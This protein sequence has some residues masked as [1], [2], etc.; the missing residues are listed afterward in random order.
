MA[1]SHVFDGNVAPENCVGRRK[2]G[3]TEDIELLKEVVANDAHVCRRG[4]VTENFE[5]AA[6]AL[7][8]SNALPWIT[9]GKHCN[10]RYK[11][12]LAKFRRAD[13]A[14]ALASGTEEEF[15]ERDQLLADIQSAVNDNEERGHTEREESQTVQNGAYRILVPRRPNYSQSQVA[16]A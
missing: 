3:E 7:N 5:E 2:F 9:N 6:R 15:G 11:L 4:K 10:D 14:R 8:E 12:L 1:M 16:L 13:R